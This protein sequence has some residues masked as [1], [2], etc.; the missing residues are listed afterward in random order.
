[1]DPASGIY[2]ELAG[3]AGQ[4]GN[5]LMNLEKKWNKE[6]RIENRMVGS[7]FAEVNFLRNF[8]F[9]STL[10]A[11]MSQLDSRNYNPILY[12]FNPTGSKTGGDTAYVDPNN[13]VT[14]VNQGSNTWK[15]PAGLYPDLQKE[16]RRPWPDRYCRF[17]HLLQQLQWFIWHSH[18]A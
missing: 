7:V 15:I 5:P 13:R 10:Y 16:F 18:P 11:D 9:R 12:R 4:I 2:Y 3:Q 14:S 8:N 17:H 6:I 1:M